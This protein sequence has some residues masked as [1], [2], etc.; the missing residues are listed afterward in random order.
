MAK[1]NA[2]ATVVVGGVEYTAT[3]V[4]RGEYPVTVAGGGQTFTGEWEP[5][6]EYVCYE[7]DTTIPDA[8]REAVN[9]AMPAAIRA[10]TPRY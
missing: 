9:A 1:A 10:V 2:V 7:D 5:A 4:R 3:L 6:L 8:V